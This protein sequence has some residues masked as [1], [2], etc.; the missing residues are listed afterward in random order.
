MEAVRC[1]DGGGISG[2]PVNQPNLA[3]CNCSPAE[4]P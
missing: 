2:G 4:L 1:A 3:F